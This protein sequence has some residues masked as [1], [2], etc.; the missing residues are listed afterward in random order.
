[1]EAGLALSIIEAPL[2]AQERLQ[3]P[4][5]MQDHCRALGV[6]PLGNA[7]GNN[8]TDFAGLSRGPQVILDGFSPNAI[9]ALSGC[10]IA[11]LVGM[12]TVLWYSKEDKPKMG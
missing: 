6:S 3:I 2:Q 12:T 4:Q 5:V 10:V 8:G 9:G 11:A 1:M 7:A